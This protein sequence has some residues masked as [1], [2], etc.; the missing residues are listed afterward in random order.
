MT[1]IVA[2]T[3]TNPA[4]R[5]EIQTGIEGRGFD[6]RPCS[7]I[8]GRERWYVDGLKGNE[9]LACA[10][11]AALTGEP[12]IEEALANPLTGRV[13]VRYSPSQTQAP[14]EVLIRRALAVD[15][16]IER[17]FS[18]PV[19]SKAF[20]LPKRL[21]VAELGCSSLKLLLLGGISCPVGAI[22]C[23]AGVLVA[24]RFAVLQSS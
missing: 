10:I 20:L 2:V 18:R 11:E 7:R 5:P 23:V 13:L 16:T 17:S 4:S 24:L 12:G 8:H 15:I 3:Q 1:Q 14:V 6:L 22:A 19:T 9:R 21:L